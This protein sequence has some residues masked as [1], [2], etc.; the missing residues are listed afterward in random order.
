MGLP[1][2]ARASGY[3][4]AAR[5]RAFEDNPPRPSR[6]HRRPAPDALLCGEA[7]P[8]RPCVRGSGAAGAGGWWQVWPRASGAGNR[9]G[10]NAAHTVDAEGP[11]AR[12]AGQ[13]DN[14]QR[15]GCRPPPPGAPQLSTVPLPG[16]ALPGRAMGRGHRCLV[17]RGGAVTAVLARQLV[18]LLAA[19]PCPGISRDSGLSAL[20]DFLVAVRD[21]L[22][23]RAVPR[24][25][26][27]RILPHGRT[28]AAVPLSQARSK[29]SSSSGMM[30]LF[31]DLHLRFRS[32][33]I[34]VWRGDAVQELFGGSGV[35]TSPSFTKKMFA[36]VRHGDEPPVKVDHHRIGADPWDLCS[37]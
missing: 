11:Q 16:P 28:S 32:I 10:G 31:V 12:I 26:R 7:L 36:P 15:R 8:D 33:P 37:A 21:F 24:S 20:H 27:A 6:A 14:T 3:R 29:P 25:C 4:E 34:T 13:Q 23:S 2:A 18:G 1:S 35:C 9:P 22:V 17:S 19:L 5:R 30:W